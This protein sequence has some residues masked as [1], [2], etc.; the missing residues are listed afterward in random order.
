MWFLDKRRTLHDLAYPSHSKSK[1]Y[2]SS[3][4]R[5]IR[6]KLPLLP[7]P[8]SRRDYVL[9][10][11]ALLL[12]GIG[13]Y[14]VVDT[15][16]RWMWLPKYASRR[17]MDFRRQ[18]FPS[19]E[20]RVR[21]YMSNWYK[22]PC[23]SEGQVVYQFKLNNTAPEEAS[24]WSFFGRSRNFNDQYY[25]EI[26]E[27][28]STLGNSKDYPQRTVVLTNKVQ[29]GRM[30][31]MEEANLDQCY[32]H[33]EFSIRF[34]CSDSTKS[35]IYTAMPDIGWSKDDPL[36][37]L[38]QFSDETESFALDVADVSSWQ[39]DP[40]IPHIK[41][42][43]FALSREEI[44]RLTKP[45]DV[46]RGEGD[47][48]H[49][50]RRG[51]PKGMS[52]MQPIIWLLNINRHF[53]YSW[54]V[55]RYDIP[56]ND[57]RDAAIFRG[58]LTGL[59]YDPDASDEENCHNLIRCRLVYETADSK[60][61]DAKITSTFDKVPEM[62]NGVNLTGDSLLKEEMLTY[63]GFI[64]LEGNDVSSGLKWAMVSNSVVLM[65][66]PRFTSWAMEEL[67]EPWVH[68][69]PIRSD[70][71]DVEEK[72]QWMLDHQA[73]AQRISH[74]ASLWVLD[75]YYH[76]DAMKDNRLIN[77]AVLRRYRAHF[78]SKGADDTSVLG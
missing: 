45:L 39:S 77:Q 58:L 76:P 41:K 63:K 57:K 72:V 61:V 32:K 21:M 56:W 20:D 48:C 19:V 50:G 4:A 46:I 29:I 73:E 60:I 16:L 78:R 24:W 47:D 52:Q 25:Y 49:S 30:F 13:V 51:P 66:R 37:V 8:M 59:E 44:D 64:I 70:L 40:R 62:F 67:L 22:P 74:R 71:S 3:E 7:Y 27:L 6:K 28:E 31:Y 26:K 43:R 17:E 12:T 33:R 36:P 23:D 68:F 42:I 9:L 53:K 15:V 34:Y 38:C 69:I 35:I 10:G 1:K 18:R 11:S 65:P 14:K 55:R 5:W 54:D 75:L 2:R